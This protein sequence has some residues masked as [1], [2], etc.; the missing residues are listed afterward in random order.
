MDRYGKS[1]V[2][3]GGEEKDR[4]DTDE[5]SRIRHSNTRI[6]PSRLSKLLDSYSADEEENE[7]KPIVSSI[8]K[9]LLFKTM[10]LVEPVSMCNK[11][12][13]NT[14]PVRVTHATTAQK[15]KRIS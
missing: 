8:T 1:K 13:A 14:D 6:E 4:N 10:R 5:R 11:S 9:E 3:R 12:R 7:K 15:K 2:K